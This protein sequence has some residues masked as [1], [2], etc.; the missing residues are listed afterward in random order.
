MTKR[1][2]RPGRILVEVAGPSLQR[3]AELLPAVAAWAEAEGQPETSPADVVEL[4]IASLHESVFT[5]AR[6]I[7]REQSEAAETEGGAL[8]PSPSVH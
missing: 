6:E 1:T 2:E 7:V 4:A 3:L 8:F 5:K